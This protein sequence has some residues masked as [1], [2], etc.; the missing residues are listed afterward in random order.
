M[1]SGAAEVANPLLALRLQIRIVH[2]RRISVCGRAPAFQC[3]QIA[4][5]S[6]ASCEKA[7]GW[8]SRS[9]SALAIRDRRS[10]T[11]CAPGRRRRAGPFS[12]ILGTD[13]LFFVRANKD[14]CARARYGPNAPVVV[15]VFLTHAS[16]IPRRRFRPGLVAFAME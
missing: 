6:S 1:A 7:G 3:D 9:C 12:C 15:V 14:A 2:E 10:G 5:T 8:A 4:A 11:C 13:V 16:E